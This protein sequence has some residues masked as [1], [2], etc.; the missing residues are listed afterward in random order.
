MLLMMAIA[1]GAHLPAPADHDDEVAHFEVGHGGHG[2]PLAEQGE[3]LR[4][5]LAKLAPA[6]PT[7]VG[8][9]LRPADRPHSINHPGFL[10]HL[11]RD[12]PSDARPRAPP[13]L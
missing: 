2:H 4:T 11:S 10:T 1:A 8:F 13:F 12:P 7:A 3:Q 9:W 6:I 5:E